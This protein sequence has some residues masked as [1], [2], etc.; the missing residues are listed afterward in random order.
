MAVG[1]AINEGRG[2][3]TSW[4]PGTRRWS[5]IDSLGQL[6]REF[7][8]SFT[9]RLSLHCPCACAA[10]TRSAHPRNG[11]FRIRRAITA[12]F[13]SPLLL[14]TRHAILTS[15]PPRGLWS[16]CIRAVLFAAFSSTASNVHHAR[17]SCTVLGRGLSSPCGNTVMLCTPPLCSSLP[18]IALPSSSVV[19]HA[20]A[21]ALPCLS[22]ALLCSIAACSGKGGSGH[23]WP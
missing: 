15:L 3:W 6:L 13:V 1:C 7:Q 5:R 11:S 8:G 10:E 21:S 20:F 12:A 14:P 23:R 17:P 4:T 18:C 19:G 2:C 22:C 16:I 9:H